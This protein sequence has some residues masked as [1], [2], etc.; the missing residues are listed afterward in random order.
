MYVKVSKSQK[1]FSLN[2]IAQKTNEILDKILLYETLAE[3]YLIFCLFFGAMEFQEK[4]LF[5]FTNITLIVVATLEY[6][7]FIV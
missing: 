1:H 3:F 6:F 2:F 7:L 5:R 4:F